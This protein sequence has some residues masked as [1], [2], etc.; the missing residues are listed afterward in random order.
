[1][2]FS[3]I[4]WLTERTN[5]GDAIGVL[6]YGMVFAFIESVMVFIVVA[7]L[8]I[9]VPRRWD[10]RRVALLSILF[11]ITAIWGMVGQEYFFLKISLPD[12]IVQ[13]LVH[14]AHPVRIMYLS[15][16]PFVFLTVAAPTYFILKF[17]KGFKVAQDFI[18]RVTLLALFYLLLGFIGLVIVILRNISGR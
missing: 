13:A 15:V 14:S 4:S 2:G 17:D 12:G 6:S 7:L 10:D 11:L 5:F 9:L 16:L 1:M 3:D 8:G 18:E